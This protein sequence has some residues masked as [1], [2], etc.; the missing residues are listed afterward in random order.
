MAVSISMR[1]MV[2]QLQWLSK[3]LKLSLMTTSFCEATMYKHQTT[4]KTPSA[5]SYTCTARKFICPTRFD[6]LLNK[7]QKCKLIS[8]RLRIVASLTA[9]AKFRMRLASEETS[10]PSTLTS[11]RWLTKKVVQI[12]SLLWFGVNLSDPA[13]QSLHA[14]ISQNFSAKSS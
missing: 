11:S 1:S 14:C 7:R 5:W 8:Y 9:M 2:S 10:L 13:Q 12:R 4:Q 6:S 3:I